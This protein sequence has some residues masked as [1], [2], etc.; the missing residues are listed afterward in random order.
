MEIMSLEKCVKICK[1][2]VEV[3]LVF[4]NSNTTSGNQWFFLSNRTIMRCQGMTAFVGSLEI[5]L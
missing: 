5:L 3:I 1:V 4:T 2:S